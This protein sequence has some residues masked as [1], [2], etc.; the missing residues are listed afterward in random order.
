MHLPEVKWLMLTLSVTCQALLTSGSPKLRSD[1]FNLVIL[2]NNDMH[3]RFEETERNSGTCQE[4]N[5]NVSCIGEY[6]VGKLRKYLRNSTG[7]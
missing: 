2:H 3:G 4:A 7:N 5:R 6:S 1:D